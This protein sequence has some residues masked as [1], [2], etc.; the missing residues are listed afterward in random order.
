[1]Y[2]SFLVHSDQ[3]PKTTLHPQHC[4]Q[5]WATA[6]TMKLPNQNFSLQEK[7]E[8]EWLDASKAAMNKHTKAVN[9]KQPLIK[10]Y[11]GT[12]PRIGHPPRF[13]YPETSQMNYV[14]KCSF[15][16]KKSIIEK[17]AQQGWKNLL[18]FWDFVF[19]F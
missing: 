19:K 7:S 18:E 16:E 15:V 17:F 11:N 5:K 9:A 1:M 10:Q 14:I 8:D 13:L 6:Q 4:T 2:D 12:S 3:Y